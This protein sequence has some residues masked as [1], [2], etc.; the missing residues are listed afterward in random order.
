MSLVAGINLELS[1]GVG[2]II[3]STFLDNQLWTAAAVRA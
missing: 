3:F 2:K 1:W